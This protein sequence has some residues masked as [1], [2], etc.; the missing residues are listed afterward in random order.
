MQVWPQLLDCLFHLV[1]E[2]K[3]ARGLQRL[4]ARGEIL[5][6]GFISV[7]EFNVSRVNVSCD[8]DDIVGCEGSLVDNMALS[9]PQG[10]YDEVEEGSVLV[11]FID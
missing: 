3:F 2:E 5:D 4:G 6:L 8:V 1:T 10:W 11:P 9:L 7:E